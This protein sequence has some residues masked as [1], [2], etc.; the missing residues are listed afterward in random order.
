MRTEAEA[1]TPSDLAVPLSVTRLLGLCLE[2]RTMGPEGKQES[3][4]SNLL[5]S[6]GSGQLPWSFLQEWGIIFH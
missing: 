6:R 5:V 4:Q 3:R 1:G 2:P